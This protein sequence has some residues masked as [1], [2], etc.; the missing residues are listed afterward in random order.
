M[1]SHPLENEEPDS[2]PTHITLNMAVAYSLIRQRKTQRD[3][4]SA[5][6]GLRLHR[7]GRPIAELVLS[8]ASTT[9]PFLQLRPSHETMLPVPAPQLH[10]LGRQ[11]IAMSLRQLDRDT[12]RILMAQPHGTA[13]P[14]E[15][16]IP[17]GLPRVI[18]LATL[19]AMVGAGSSDAV[20]RRGRDGKRWE[21]CP[22]EYQVDLEDR[23]QVFKIREF[24]ILS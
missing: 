13:Q 2:V 17:A 7:V 5:P 14:L 20:F 15:L 10:S 23:T 11:P 18:N 6:H 8:Q 1:N 9:S 19:K 3:L 22:D 4:P 21:L 12:Y 16:D 24:A